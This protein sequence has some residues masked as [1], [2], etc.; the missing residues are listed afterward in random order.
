MKAL[1]RLKLDLERLN[2]GLGRLV[3]EDVG[4]QNIH[5]FTRFYLTTYEQDKKGTTFVP[6]LSA[7]AVA[8][9]SFFFKSALVI[10]KVKMK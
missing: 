5:T 4:E 9:Q 1:K 7:V 8:V 2:K 6:F 3:I 10:T